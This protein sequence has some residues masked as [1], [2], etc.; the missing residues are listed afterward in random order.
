MSKKELIK[1]IT[2]LMRRATDAQLDLVWWFLR[3]M[4][5]ENEK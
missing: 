3:E 1:E 2:R 5:G 4:I